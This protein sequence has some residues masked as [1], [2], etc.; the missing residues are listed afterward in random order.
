VY[1]I[2]DPPPLRKSGSAGNR[3]RT[4]RSV[5]RNSDHWTI[6][7]VYYHLHNIYKFSSYLTGNSTSPFCSQEFWSL[8]HRGRLLSST[9]ITYINSVRTSQETQ[10]ISVLQPGTLIPRPQR[11]S[12]TTQ[13]SVTL[14]TWR[15]ISSN[16]GTNFANKRRSLGRYSSLAGSGTEFLCNAPRSSRNFSF[17]AVYCCC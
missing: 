9:Y 3:T 13:T 16:V 8:D 4:S 17:R 5:A 11:R 2:P 1:P 10:Y 14:T 12:G 7:A 15:P 6:E